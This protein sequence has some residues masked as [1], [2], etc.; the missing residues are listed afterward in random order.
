[1][2]AAFAR[3]RED[4]VFQW[5]VILALL[6]EIVVYIEP[7]PVDGVIIF[8]IAVALLLGKLSF[9][10]LSMTPV[11]ALAVFALANVVSMYDP[12]DPRRAVFYL[13]VTFYLVASWF[14]F[15]GV[16]GRYGKPFLGTAI[17]TY[18]FAGLISAVLGVGGYFGLIPFPDLL[19]LAGRARGL[20]K[21]CNVYGPFFVP[22]ALF[23]FTRILDARAG[24]SEKVAPALVMGLA[25]LAMM[26]SFSRAC[27]INFG[28]A[29]GVF[30]VGQVA[31]PGLRNQLS[32]PELRVRL[33][34]C[35]AVVGAAIIALALLTAVPSVSEMLSQRVTSNGLQNYDRTR[36][37]TQNL[38]LE[39]AERRPLGMGP[40]Q[41]ELAFDYSTHSMYLRILTE[42][43]IIALLALLV[44]IGATIYRSI[45]VI[46]RAEDPWYKEINLVVL[47]CIAGHLVNSLVIDTVHWRHIWFIYA[48]PWAPVQF[49]DFRMRMAS[50]IPRVTVDRRA[51][52]GT[53]AYTRR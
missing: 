5:L 10:G 52:F 29:A 18:C 50:A 46:G 40:G 15:V 37:A 42:N 19:L 23:G 11:V 24:L 43:G 22:M 8:C 30:L 27:W 9:R 21:D 51:T 20:F 17:D 48:L 14:F 32:R 26:L 6:L 3:T 1:M 45:A 39:M 28:V 34:I 36:F 35:G 7:A 44:F 53:P 16:F 25:V 31:F 12:L 13:L 47:A 4:V 38:A 49:H 33:W 2:T 41:V